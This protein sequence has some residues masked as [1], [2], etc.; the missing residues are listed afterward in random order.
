MYKKIPRATLHK[1]PTMRATD[2][3]SCF[4]SK[5]IREGKLNWDPEFRNSIIIK[6]FTQKNW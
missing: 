4:K 1:R 2:G 3:F 6:V 5:D